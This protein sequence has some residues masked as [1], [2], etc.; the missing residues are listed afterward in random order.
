MTTTC[1]HLDQIH[2][3]TPSSQ[4]CEDCLRI[5]GRWVHLRMCLTCGH[6]GCCDSSE[7]KH[8]TKHFHMTGHPLVQ[9]IEPGEDW[10]WCYV[11][12]VHVRG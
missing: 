10:R 2:S 3:V 6:V 1:T 12:K 8:A 11:D 9:S 7:H 5:G 4:G